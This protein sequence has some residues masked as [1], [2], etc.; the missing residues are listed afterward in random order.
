MQGT[1]EIDLKE[2]L[3]SLLYKAWLIILVAALFAGAVY[4]YTAYFVTPM[5]KAKVSIYVNNTTSGNTQSG[6]SSSDLTASQ[7]LVKTYVNFLSTDTVLEKVAAEVGHNM[8][9]SKIRSMME[10]SDLN[11]TEAFE[12]RISN[13]DPELAAQIANAIAAIAPDVI[14]SYIPGSSTKVM[15]YAKVPSAPY[16]PDRGKNALT[17]FLVG[18]ALAVVLVVLQVVLDVRI[19]DEHD[20]QQLSSAAVLGVIPNFEA[21]PKTGYE[22]ETKTPHSNKEVRQ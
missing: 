22:Y 6:V 9:A 15:D 18:A 1:M 17:G 7:K 8:T 5:Y 10:A 14:L 21:E 2:I 16:T 12:V 4:A 13:A 11:G 20:L 3:W 19:K